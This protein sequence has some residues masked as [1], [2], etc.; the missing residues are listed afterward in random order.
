MTSG[1]HERDVESDACD[2]R[3]GHEVHNR[4]SDVKSK[5]GILRPV[6]TGCDSSYYV[7][8]AYLLDNAAKG[9]ICK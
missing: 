4:S 6:A 3:V 8:I 5:R 9:S 1:K 2:R 7:I